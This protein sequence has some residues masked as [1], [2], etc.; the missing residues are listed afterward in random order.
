MAYVWGVDGTQSTPLFARLAKEVLWAV[1]ENQMTLNEVKYL[2]D[3]VNKRTRTEL[4]EGLS[5]DSVKRGWEFSNILSPKDFNTQFSSTVNRFYSFLD[6]EKM[7][8]MFG[9]SGAS[10]DLG[11]A[12]DAGQIIIVNASTEGV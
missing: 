2:I 7:R 1:Y 6:S 3:S 4:T 5:K 9:Q 8:L 12:L 10:L 11:K